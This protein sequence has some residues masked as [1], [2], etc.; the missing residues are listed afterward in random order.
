MATE[1]CADIYNFRVQLNLN[2]YKILMQLL[3][4]ELCIPCKR[5]VEVL[6]PSASECDLRW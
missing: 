6:T 2:P 5:C 3:R 4:V 1:L